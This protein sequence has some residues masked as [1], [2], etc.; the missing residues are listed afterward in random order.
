MAEAL[1]QTDPEAVITYVG[2]ADGPEASLVPEAGL[3]F[4][5]LRLGSMGSSARSSAPRLALRLPVAYGQ[6][7]RLLRRFQPQVVLA[8]GGYVC[9]PVAL[10]ARRRRLPVVLLEQNMLPGRAVQWLAPRVQ[11][12][13]SSFPA[14]AALLPRAKVVCTGNPVRNS[15]A[16]LAGRPQLPEA[17]P[18]LLVMGGSQGARSLNEVLLDALPSLLRQLPQLKVVHLT[19]PTDFD[20]VVTVAEER[21]LPVGNAYQPLPFVTDVAERLAGA[22]LAVM[23]AGGSSLAEVACLGRPMVLVPYPHASEH[24]SANAEPFAESGAALVIPDQDLTAES[25][26]E[27]VLGVL[28]DPQRWA[29]M[30]RASSSMARPQ[31]AQDVA[32]LLQQLAQTRG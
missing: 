21:G 17:P 18:T 25:L 2:R 27:A 16:A 32:R 24:Q 7:V 15:F 30:A 4:S 9:V 26:E 22:S 20:Q 31:A 10:A 8:T 13:A 29:T 5:G 12:V 6:A 1:R 3:D 23:R 14:T 19:G 28:S 11:R